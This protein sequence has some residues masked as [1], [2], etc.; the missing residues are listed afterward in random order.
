MAYRSTYAR[1]ECTDKATDENQGQL[2][3]HICASALYYY[4]EENIT[5]SYLA[6][7]EGVDRDI[8]MEQAEQSREWGF[9]AVYC[10]EDHWGE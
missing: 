8:L 10:I 9:C 3:E 1:P 7:R 2:N 5:P 4:D 6:F